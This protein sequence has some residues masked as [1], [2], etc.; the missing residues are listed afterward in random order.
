MKDNA[1]MLALFSRFHK[2][3]RRFGVRALKLT[4]LPGHPVIFVGGTH[5]EAPGPIDFD[6]QMVVPVFGGGDLAP[7]KLFNELIFFFGS[8]AA[9]CRCQF[10]HAS[11]HHPARARR[12]PPVRTRTLLKSAKNIS[13]ALIFSGLAF[14]QS[15]FI[16]IYQAQSA[17]SQ[18]FNNINPKYNAWTVMYNYSGSGS[19]SIEL[20]CAADATTAGG[21]PTPGTYLTC[22]NTVTGSNPAT[23]PNYG[24]ITFVGYTPWLK[25]NVTA[26]S[27]GN[28]TAV[29]VGFNPAD[30]ESTSSGSGGCAGTASTPCIVAGPNSPGTPSTKSPV[31]IAGND[32]T[33]V[34]SILTDSG[35]R[36]VVLP[37]QDSVPEPIIVGTSQTHFALSA[38]TDVVIISG[39][40]GKTTYLT[41]VSVA[42]DAAA[43]AT[44]RQG[45]TS[46][47]PC[48]TSTATI[49]GPY[50]NGNITALVLDYGSD[51]SPLTTSSTGLDIC[52]HLSASA[53]GGGGAS[54]NQH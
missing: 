37:G 13:I 4:R 30:P 21:T 36:V 14:A 1:F 35:G 47:T 18:Q 41:R 24:Y 17:T 15:G 31:Q 25:L 32:G 3:L 2:G 42:W 19:F 6:H 20:D 7:D 5:D 46:S 22:S 40:S 39:T 45:T 23:T 10:R 51:F 38:A 16:Q 33:D 48:D 52:L 12:Q 43:T 11:H 27:S 8:V 9:F 44:I 53:T 26:I 54:Y 34:R 50:G 28:M 29:A 49:D